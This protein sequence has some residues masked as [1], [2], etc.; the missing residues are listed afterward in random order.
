MVTINQIQSGILQYI[1]K[2]LM[3]HLDGLKKV[4]LGVYATLAAGNIAAM[5]MSYKDHP[6][7]KMLDVFGENNEIDIDKLYNAAVPYYSNGEKQTVSIPLI[8]D[9]TMDKSDI[10]KLYR[11][12]K[13]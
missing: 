8:G 12:I 2:D 9:F 10:D 4:G 11:Y 7:V 5:I 6:A 1:E 13:G 3:P